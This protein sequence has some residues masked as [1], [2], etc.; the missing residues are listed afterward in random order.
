M[1]GSCVRSACT[2][3]FRMPQAA[4][5]MPQTAHRR[6]QAASRKP[7]RM[8]CSSTAH[9]YLCAMFSPRHGGGGSFFFPP[10]VRAVRPVR[11]RRIG[12]DCLRNGALAWFHAVEPSCQA[13]ACERAWRRGGAHRASTACGLGITCTAARTMRRTEH[14]YGVRMS[15][16]DV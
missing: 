12:G 13:C 11:R 1:P 2:P 14:E 8:R 10:K 9:T 5:L 7:R 15:V 16:R 4:S 3:S 6:P